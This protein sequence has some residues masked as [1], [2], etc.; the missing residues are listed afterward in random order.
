MRPATI[1]K[2][3]RSGVGKSRSDF[4]QRDVDRTSNTLSYA[5]PSFGSRWT[6][7]RLTSIRVTEKPARCRLA[8]LLFAR[9]ALEHEAHRA[10]LRP[11]RFALL[12]GQ[13]RRSIQRQ[14][15]DVRD[16]GWP[17]ER[18]GR[19]LDQAAPVRPALRPKSIPANPDHELAGQAIA[20][21]PDAV[22][23]VRRIR[24]T[25]GQIQEDGR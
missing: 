20:P 12:L 3:E 18:R 16:I 2:T 23:P 17:L 6:A 24:H 5:D 4:P 8:S 21:G 25:G 19:R 14:R 9:Y 13:H 15:V 11:H 7:A 10:L 1:C 22:L